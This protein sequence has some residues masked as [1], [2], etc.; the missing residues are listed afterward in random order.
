MQGSHEALRGAYICTRASVFVGTCD[1]P[2][3]RGVYAPDMRRAIP[4][5]RLGVEADLTSL[6][7]CASSAWLQG[8]CLMAVSNLS[9]HRLRHLAL[10]RPG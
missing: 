2:F 4:A 10:V 9:R 6:V 5:H 8:P 3:S 1:M 7:S